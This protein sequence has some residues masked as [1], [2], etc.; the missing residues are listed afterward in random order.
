M[1]EIEPRDWEKPCAF[2]RSRTIPA[3]SFTFLAVQELAVHGWDIRSKVEPASSLSADCVPAL[4]ERI[5][6]RPVPWLSEFVTSSQDAT[7]IR[8]RFD[9]NGVSPGRYD[10]VVENNRAQLKRAVDIPA[11]VNCS[12]DGGIFVLLMYGRLT[13]EA[14]LADGRL[15]IVGD[16]S[17]ISD[18]DRWLKGAK[19]PG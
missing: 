12:C 9:L 8:Y 15:T 10:V 6:L 7:Q 2:W 18:I 3:E 14:V 13:V 1:A 19:R 16:H 17:L 5:P 11:D 4:L